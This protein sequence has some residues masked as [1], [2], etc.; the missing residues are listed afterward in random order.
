M[1]ETQKDEEQERM[2]YSMYNPNTQNFK[3]FEQGEEPVEVG[4]IMSVKT[5]LEK[6]KYMPLGKIEPRKAT[7]IPTETPEPTIQTR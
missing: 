6:G 7:L 4:G 5:L 2:E 1:T 3:I